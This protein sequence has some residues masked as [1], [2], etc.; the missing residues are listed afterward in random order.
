MNIRDKN[1]K[2]VTRIPLAIFYTGGKK[3]SWKDIQNIFEKG[4]ESKDFKTFKRNVAKCLCLIKKLNMTINESDMPYSPIR[5][6]SLYREIYLKKLKYDEGGKDVKSI[7]NEFLKNGKIQNAEYYYIQE[8]INKGLFEEYG[9]L[10]EW[11]AKNELQENL[12]Y[13]ACLCLAKLNP[14]AVMVAFLQAVECLIGVMQEIEKECC[15]YAPIPEEFHPDIG[16]FDL[17]ID[18]NKMTNEESK[19]IYLLLEKLFGISS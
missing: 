1:E 10:E 2:S 13:L 9:I 7:V 17:P 16:E 14:P 6:K 12:Y 3:K 5:L 18:C 8:V 15:N 11:Y 19:K 4:Y